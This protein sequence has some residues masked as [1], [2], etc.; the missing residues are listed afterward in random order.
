MQTEIPALDTSCPLCCSERISLF[1]T[2]KNRQYLSCARCQLVFVP[3]RYW[4][5]AKAEKAIYDLHENDAQDQGYRKFLSRLSSPLL[6]RLTPA[7]KGL[8]F[9]CGPGPTL[10]K[11]LIEQGHEV[12]LFDPFYFNNPGALTK[13]YDFICA[14]EVVEHLHDPNKEFSTLFSLLK[15]GGWM[16]IMTKLVIDLQAFSNWHYIR[17]LTHISF[18][19]R[20]TFEYLAESYSAE[21][22]FIDNDVILL[23]KG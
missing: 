8:D 14:T 21:L 7:Q 13:I 3:E 17:D 16:G 5:N 1:F 18:F 12:D 22:C 10:A 15:P 6:E 11:I 19:S 2:D 23:R 20:N 4:L 9:G